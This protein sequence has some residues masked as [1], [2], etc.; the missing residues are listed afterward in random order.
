MS[1]ISPSKYKHPGD[2]AARTR[3]LANVR[4]GLLLL[5]SLALLGCMSGGKK[6]IY[7]NK[8]KHNYYKDAVAEVE[9]PSV[10]TETNPEAVASLPPRSIKQLSDTDLWD[11]S[12]AETIHIAMANSE[13][14]KQSAQFLSPQNPLLNNPLGADSI[15]DPAI[16]ETG[17]LIGNRGVEAALADFDA[18]VT[19]SALWGRNEEVQNSIFSSG[20]L[21]A[22]SVLTQET[23]AFNTRLQKQLAQGGSFAVS[24]N[25]NYLGS[26]APSRLFPS[27]YTGSVQAEFRQPLMAGRGA[28]FTRIAGPIGNNLAGVSGVNQGVVISRINN[29]IVISRLQT[30]L[31]N[32][33]LD[34][35]DLY[36]NLALAYRVYDSQKMSE[37]FSHQIWRQIAARQGESFDG[38]GYAQVSQARADY[39]SA[40][41][42]A[43]TALND[44][45]DAE[46]RLRRMLGLP[47]NDGRLIRPSTEAQLAEFI[48]D[49]DLA[50]LNALSQRPELRQ[51]KWEIQSLELQ[52]KAAKSLLKPRIDFVSSYNVN[53][54][55]DHLRSAND[56]D[57]VTG[58][59]FDSA[60]ESLT[61]GEQTGWN[62]GFEASVPIG[63]RTAHARVQ[64]LEFTL[65]KAKAVLSIQ[66]KEICDELASS[67]SQMEGFYVR[68]KTNF[69]SRKA[70]ADFLEAEEENFKFSRTSLDQLLRAR[71]G[72]V[73]AEVSFFQSV[74]QYNQAIAEVH[75]RQGILLKENNITMIEGD[76]KKEA[77][78]QS[79]RREIARAHGWDDDLGL[80][81]SEP[82]EF[83]GPEPPLL[84]VHRPESRQEKAE[85][86]PVRP[87]PMPVPVPD[88]DAPVA[89]KAPTRSNQSTNSWKKAGAQAAPRIVNQR[90]L[91][92][93][94]APPSV[95]ES[96]PSF[97]RTVDSNVQPASGWKAR[98]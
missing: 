7:F 74:V 39:Y 13:V 32:M 12:I 77:Y 9:Y 73:E 24:N 65:R 6:L 56:N 55:G 50:R 90:R 72:L 71:L 34:V 15:F 57:G 97:T 3:R 22:G 87:A 43:Q 68:A 19:T 81:H 69:A 25:L 80:L 20:G 94:P 23:A 60:M 33:M 30:A 35:E 84:D 59:G 37:N 78:A 44:L 62:L 18:T 66:E 28:E 16:Q 58:Q 52:H 2:N 31:N 1:K 85:P 89:R 75:H 47:A 91:T 11:L 27:A 48:P 51:T 10:Y 41:E 14:I 96:A 36:W 92:P 5:V 21:P 79:E 70:S 83:I 38:G 29:D 8:P 95:P 46:L 26:N 61:A 40:R 67:I 17:V 88:A 93:P 82:M 98:D 64:N 86:Q 76:W 45:Y 53:S 49:W 4:V 42:R 63:Q 54:F